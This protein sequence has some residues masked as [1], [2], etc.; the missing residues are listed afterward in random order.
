[1]CK[2]IAASHARILEQPRSTAMLFQWLFLYTPSYSLIQ[3]GDRLAGVSYAHLSSA[4]LVS[5]AAIDAE[6][7]AFCNYFKS[8]LN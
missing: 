1:M 3:L 5:Y 6:E 2:S 7:V 8:K 4:R